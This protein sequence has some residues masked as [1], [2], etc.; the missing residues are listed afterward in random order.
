MKKCEFKMFEKQLLEAI[1]I[2]YKNKKLDFL[3]KDDN[4]LQQDIVIDLIM[5]DG[6]PYIRNKRNFGGETSKSRY[7]KEY[8]Y[9]ERVTPTIWDIVFKQ[10]KP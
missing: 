3:L 1:K 4:K 9:D 6:I 10:E 7:Y 2:A 8:K 5:Y